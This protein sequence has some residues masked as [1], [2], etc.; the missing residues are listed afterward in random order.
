M[1]DSVA[2]DMPDIRRTLKRM[3][4]ASL[5]GLPFA[6]GDVLLIMRVAEAAVAHVD[7]SER[8]KEKPRR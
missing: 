4:E 7:A 6:V 1:L 5:R 8:E 2:S 3:E